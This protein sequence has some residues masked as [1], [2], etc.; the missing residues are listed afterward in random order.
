MKFNH[1]EQEQMLDLG[2]R[3]TALF[4]V[5]ELDEAAKWLLQGLERLN[6]SRLNTIEERLLR[7]LEE[8][9]LFHDVE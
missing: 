9:Y 3:M 7:V 6:R 2:E 8:F 4:Q 5:G 1:A